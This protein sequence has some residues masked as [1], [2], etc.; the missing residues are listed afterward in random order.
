MNQR[1]LLLQLLPGFIPLFAFIVADELWGTKIG[2]I[3]AIAF[4]IIELA[5]YW[6]KDRKNRQIYFAR[7]ITHYCSWIGFHCAR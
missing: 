3:V 7:Y 5:W 1:K 6:I 2:L 4:G